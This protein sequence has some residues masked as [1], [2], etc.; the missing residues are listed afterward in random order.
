MRRPADWILEHR[1]AV[2]IIRIA[3][4]DNQLMAMVDLCD[5]SLI[6]VNALP[7]GYYEVFF[8]QETTNL[9]NRGVPNHIWTRPNTGLR[10]HDS[11]SNNYTLYALDVVPEN[12]DVEVSSTRRTMQRDSAVVRQV[13][14]RRQSED[15]LPQSILNIHLY[16]Y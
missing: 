15:D 1:N 5:S 16:R 2:T 14:P 8:Y 9:D 10:V 12:D 4:H 6:H 3:S 13:S 11:S 7:A